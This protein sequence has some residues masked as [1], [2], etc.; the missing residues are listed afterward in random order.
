MESSSIQKEEEANEIHC[1]GCGRFLGLSAIAVGAV[2]IL[3]PKCKSW[4]TV[5]NWPDGIDNGVA[6]EYTDGKSIRSQKDLESR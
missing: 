2:Q 5:S 4:T 3:C 6:I 1:V